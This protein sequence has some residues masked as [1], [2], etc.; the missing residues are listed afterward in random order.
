[1]AYNKE[2]F[3]KEFEE[4]LQEM[5]KDRKNYK[6]INRDSLNYTSE[7]QDNDDIGSSIEWNKDVLFGKK[8]VII[9]E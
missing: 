1:M 8:Q 2:K 4:S 6:R 9:K 3:L 7:N 5:N